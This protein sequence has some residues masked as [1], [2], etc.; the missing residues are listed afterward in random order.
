MG[1][2]LMNCGHTSQGYDSKTDQ[3]VCIVCS[4]YQQA[5]NLPDLTGREA[6]CFYK[7]GCK[8]KEKSSFRLAFFKYDANN[9]YDEYYCGCKGFD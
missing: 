6:T 8:N 1:K 5:T 2:I 9:T 4:N 7:F 3:P